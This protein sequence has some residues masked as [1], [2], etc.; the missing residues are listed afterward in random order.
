[1]RVLVLLAVMALSSSFASAFTFDSDVPQ[2]IQ[3]QMIGDLQFINTIQG[4]GASQLHQQIYGQ[5]NG[6]GYTAFFTSRV[7]S[8]GLNDCGNPNAV[9]CVIPFE[10]P[11]KMWITNN[12]I[13]FSHPQVARNMVIFQKPFFTSV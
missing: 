5:V 10:N 9:A 12:Y 3:N 7:K 1:M 6:A 8:V 11:S 2:D 4:S 13:K